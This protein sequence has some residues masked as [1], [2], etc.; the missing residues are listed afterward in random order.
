[1]RNIPLTVSMAQLRVPPV[2]I[3]AAT[4]FTKAKDKYIG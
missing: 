3:L 1:M 2:S 4:D